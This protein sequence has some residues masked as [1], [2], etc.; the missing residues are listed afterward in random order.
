M[1][2]ETMEKAE[3][4]IIDITCT[5]CGAAA[6]FNI[7]TQEYRCA[8]CGSVISIEEAKRQKQGFK[9]IHAEKFRD[10]VKNYHL[11]SAH[12]SGCGADIIF[13]ENEALSRC[14]FCGKTLI[15]RDYL[16]S[17]DLPEYIVPFALS[18]TEAEELLRSWCRNNRKKPESARLQRTA[19]QLKGFYLPYELVRGPVHLQVSRMDGSRNYSCEGYISDEFVNCSEQ[20]DNLL[21]DGMEPFDLNSLCEFDPGFIAGQRIK[22]SDVSDRDLERRVSAEMEELYAPAIRKVLETGA[23]YVSADVSSALKLPVLLPVYFISDGETMAAVNGQTGKVAVRALKDSHYYFLPWWFKAILASVILSAASYGALRLFH[24]ESSDAMIITGAL[25]LFF[26]IVIL[27]LYSDTTKNSFSVVSGRKIYTSEDAF[28]R[29]NSILV[30]DDRSTQ[31]KI[32]DP[33]FFEKLNGEYTPVVLKF[34]TPLRVLT[35]VFLSAAAIF[36]PV[37]IA[38]FLNGFDLERLNLGGSAVWFCIAVPLVPIFFLK[39]G[40]TELHDRPLIYSYKNGK[41]RRHRQKNAVS[42]DLLKM[43]LRALFIPPVSIAVWIAIIVFAV[44]CFLTA[45]GFE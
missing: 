15:R 34:T 39:F 5:N 28:I 14:A 26:I 31:R 30:P 41:L 40:V 13:E 37:I 2:I 45:F 33:L 42:R 38:L 7:V 44:I 16:N 3:S 19:E 36:L 6:S 10:S 32:S 23:V 17:G 43:I 25:S 1:Q 29:K 24:M 20:L 27:C 11:F 35:M 9:K 4:R 12:C 18:E 22:I 8:H 21:L